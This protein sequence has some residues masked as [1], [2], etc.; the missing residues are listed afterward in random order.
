MDQSDA[1]PTPEDSNDQGY[2]PLPEDVFYTRYFKRRVSP[3]PIGKTFTNLIILQERPPK[4]TTNGGCERWVLAQCRCGVTKE[5][6]LSTILCGR[7]RSCGCLK[8]GRA[9]APFEAGKRFGRLT[10]VSESADHL[11]AGRRI[12]M[13]SCRCDCGNSVVARRDNLISGDTTSCGCSRALAA[14]I[15]ET[16][17]RLTVESTLPSRIAPR[18]N[19]VARV[20]TRCSCGTVHDIDKNRLGWTQSCGCLARETSSVE[21]VPGRVA[22]KFV[23]YDYFGGAKMRGLPWNLTNEDF[24]RLIVQPCVYCGDACSNERPDPAGGGVFNYTG[25]DR[26][27]SRLGYVNGNVA[28]CCTRC[29]FAKRDMELAD[30]A[31]WARQFAF[32]TIVPF[33]PSSICSR[34][35]EDLFGPRSGPRG[36][37]LPPAQVARNRAFRTHRS[38]A[39]IRGLSQG[40]SREEFTA[41]ILMDCHYCGAPPSKRL[42]YR[43]RSGDSGVLIHNGIDRVDPDGGYE[44]DN[45]VPCCSICNHAK[46][47]R[48]SAEMELWRGRLKRSIDEEDRDWPSTTN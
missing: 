7:T 4:Q 1:V 24:F 45:V 31:E 33:D 18:G 19:E 30:F 9:R 43:R 13:I 17:G 25:L 36:D 12:R 20:R 39:R 11:R 16:F 14:P 8:V 26:I 6:R 48:S 10:C 22:R 5:I 2:P 29:N 35:D 46:G 28:A 34:V 42:A 44:I 3:A 40:L 32:H 47:T 15:G 38:S 37:L 27:N 23:K 41:L 21:Y